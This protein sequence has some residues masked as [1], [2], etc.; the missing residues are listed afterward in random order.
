MLNLYFVYNGHCKFY[1][2]TF[3]T[4]DD[5]IEHMEDHSGLSRLSLIQGFES[6]LVSGRYGLTTVQRI[7]TI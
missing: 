5:L 3:D 6:T 2:G 4:V 1:L 7:A